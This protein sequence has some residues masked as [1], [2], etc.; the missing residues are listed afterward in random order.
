LG[1]WFDRKLTFEEHVR[2]YTTKALTT[3]TAM[4]MLGNSM[5]G[6]SP[7]NKCILYHACV[8][9]IA[10]YGHRLWFF[11]G[12]KVKGVLKSLTSMQRKAAC[13]ITDMFRTSPT[14]GAESLAGLPPIR[15]HLQKLSQR[16][17][18]RTAT[19]SDTHPLRSLMKGT[20][21]KRALPMLGSA[22]WMSETRCQ[23]VHNT[24]TTSSD[25]WMD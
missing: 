12:A 2:F 13:W 7:R 16:A 1:F 20:H 18:L 8:L 17:I 3:V 9:P 24:I 25:C 14:G 5:R 10:M 19:L 15:I 4:R 23:Q 6:L 22:Y 11:K 21:A